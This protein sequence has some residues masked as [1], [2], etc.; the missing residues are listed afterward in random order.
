MARR[1]FGA[2]VVGLS[3]LAL[4]AGCGGRLDGD[5]V[6]LDAAVDAPPPRP[7]RLVVSPPPGTF[8]TTPSVTLAID[9]PDDRVGELDLWYTTDGATP[10]AGS[11]RRAQPGVPIV[12]DRSRG[13]RVF[14]TDAQGL[15]R[16]AFFGTYLVLDASVAT[17]SSNVPVL[18]LWGEAAVPETKLPTY[19]PSSMAVFEPAGGGARVTWPG[20]AGQ[21]VRAGIKIRGSSTSGYP[22]HPWHVETR[23]ALVDRDEGVALLG[24][25]PDSDWALGAPLDFDRALMRSSLAY[26]LSNAIELWAPRT[27][28]AEVFIAGA[29]ETVGMDDYIGVYEVTELIKRGRGRV[30]VAGLEDEDIVEPDLTGG[31]IF[32]EDRLG[33][34]ESGFRAGTG[35]GTLYFQNNFVLVDP[36]ELDAAP[37]Q[38]AY[39]KAQLDQLGL[40]V[41]SPTFTTPAGAHYR[42]LIDVEEFIDHHI[43]NLFTKNP[44]AFRLS[45]YYYKPRSAGIAAGPVWDFDRTM[46]CA[47]DSRA[48]EPT[49]W[50]NTGGTPFFDYGFYGGL[51]DDPAFAAA[52]WARLG[53]LLHGPL[54]AEATARWIDG[55]APGLQEAAARNFARWAGYPPR[56]S[57][58]NEL[59][60]LK[61]WLATR[62]AWLT[63]CLARADPRTCPE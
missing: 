4:A 40:A 7:A 47:S 30:D 45:G 38:R 41:T 20:P 31:Y 32:K 26:A 5:Y 62:S 46:G 27:A 59:M 11:S 29:G 16:F 3:A 22:K 14:A 58:G 24:M 34:G 35:G 25:A 50:G 51:F 43:I 12:L 2:V 52:Y 55:W 48:Q 60:I 53:Q 23:S 57:Y 19:T 28:F 54:S 21:V 6:P 10:V 37:E 33:P 36:E 17:F 39:L 9:D 8:A 49:G 18:V 63:G 56:G 44:D 61:S 13:L 42:D 1:T 15:V